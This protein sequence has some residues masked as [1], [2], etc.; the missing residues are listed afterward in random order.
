MSLVFSGC[1]QDVTPSKPSK[2]KVR[3]VV[4]VKPLPV[5]PVADTTPP[6]FADGAMITKSV[7]ENQISAIT[8][9]ASDETSAVSYSIVGGDS[10]L[11]KLNSQTGKV[12]FLKAPDY[13]SIPT[14]HSYIFAAIAKDKAHN[15]SSQTVIINVLDVKEVALNKPP[16]AHAG[17]NQSVKKGTTVTLDASLSRGDKG[18]K[19][20]VWSEGKRKLS[21]KKHFEISTL[22]VGTHKITLKITDKKGKIARD[23]VIV[24]VNEPLN[25]IPK[26]FSQSLRVGENQKLSIFLVGKDK[27]KDK[28][29]Y[30]IVTNPLHGSLSGKAPHL[31]YT[32][33][34]AK[35][36][37]DE[38]SFTVSDGKA[39]SATAK[40]RI[41][42]I[43]IKTKG[44]LKNGVTYNTVKSPYT[45][46]LWLDRNLGAS[47]VCT[48]FD[49][50]A[51][52]GNYYQW[53]RNHDGHQDP[54]S[55]STRIEAKNI[56]KAGK[57]F[58]KRSEEWLAVDR[59]GKKRALNW[60][61]SD[62]SSICP[63]GYRVPTNAELVAETTAASS[64]V[65]NRMDAFKNFLKLPSAGY[66]YAYSGE[67]DNQVSYG[68]VWTTT[69]IGSNEA[70]NLQFDAYG[71]GSKES[72]RAFG[73]SVR[74]VKN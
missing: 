26:A 58:I 41:K 22:S 14:K 52:Y 54:K 35:S 3:K 19:S 47:R 45:G 25:Q 8:L 53:G 6:V 30:S 23:T 55:L 73:F 66:R 60:S 5:K 61:A 11:F 10:A 33:T 16:V 69:V 71:A 28:L 18:I 74:C 48:A 44:I 34:S 51:C 4:E 68:F 72:Y 62:G 1:V 15:E 39:T 29:T 13:E 57:K 12:T 20:C 49:D 65:K 43:A 37:K 32:P 56:N 31:I 9:N 64:A 27:D 42:I 21:T 38:F 63:T 2:Q 7:N 50:V 70:K 67:Q 59:N 17:N 46:K 36:G 40:I 24:N